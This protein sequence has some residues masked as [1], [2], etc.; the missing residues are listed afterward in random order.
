MARTSAVTALTDEQLLAAVKEH[1]TMA[2]AA[3]ALG[4]PA[5]TFSGQIQERGL[6]DQVAKLRAVPN[7]DAEY[8][9]DAVK[10]VGTMRGAASWLGL[11]WATFHDRLTKAG[12]LDEAVGIA[13]SRTAPKVE[14]APQEPVGVTIDYDTGTA[15]VVEPPAQKPKIGDIGVLVRERGLDPDEWVIGSVGLNEWDALTKTEPGV[16]P[17]TVRLRQWKVTLR[18][19]PHLMLA[20]PAQHV[21]TVKMLPGPPASEKPEIVVVE[22]DHQIPFHNQQLHRA[23]VDML[24]HLSRH[25]RLAEHIYLGDTSDFPTIS[26]HAD[27]PST[28]QAK[29]NVC[30]QQTYD[31]LREKR[32]ATRGAR[33]RK[34]KGNHDWRVESELLLRAE[35]MYGIKP[36]QMPGQEEPL[37]ALSLSNLLN[38]E[39]LGIELVEDPRGWEHA[40]VE[41]VPGPRGLV[42][43]H[44]WLTGANSAKNSMTKRGR[45][46]IVGHT[47]R[48][49]HVFVW[50]ASMECERQAVTSGT[51]SLVRDQRYPHYVACDNWLQGFVVVTRWPDGRFLIEHAMWDGEALTWRDSTWRA[52][53]AP[54]IRLAA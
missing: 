18:R 53:E 4:F 54:A 34:L 27:H 7:I 39:Q 43:R 29:V 52:A 50:D 42:V 9:L 41:I 1:G 30:I 26:R 11:S 51:M 20:M 28:A 47:H 24:H 23:S 44:G 21:P 38:L 32:E 33:T 49:E 31:V 2:A 35:R 14:K 48:R 37:P 5:R 8:L 40:E 17:R 6:G 10:R 13:K 45:S 22:G 3:R 46:M 19:A 12:V 25:H 16:E 15:V 36:A